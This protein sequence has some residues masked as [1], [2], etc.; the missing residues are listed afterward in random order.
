MSIFAPRKV[1]RALSQRP[2]TVRTR[3]NEARKVGLEAATIKLNRKWRTRKCRALHEI[4]AFK[5]YQRLNEASPTKART[6]I[7]ALEAQ[8]RTLRDEELKILTNWYHNV[9]LKV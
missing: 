8:F 6:Y 1:H 2:N 9:R 5:D 7:L 4:K 3:E